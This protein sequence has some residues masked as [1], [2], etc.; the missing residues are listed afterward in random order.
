MDNKESQKYKTFDVVLKTIVVL[1]CMAFLVT[2][3]Y[4][5]VNTIQLKKKQ[6]ES[7]SATREILKQVV[8]AQTIY[9]NEPLLRIQ[10]EAIGKE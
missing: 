7:D 3:M 4:F 2:V 6:L 8:T 5:M 10:K 9:F 1:I